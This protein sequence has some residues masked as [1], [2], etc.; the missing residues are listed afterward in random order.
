ML[1][2]NL[3]GKVGLITGGSK[4][5]GKACAK[6]LAEAGATVIINF[7][8]NKE[9]AQKTAEEIGERALLHQC[10]VSNP[11]EVRAM[12]NAI[13]EK[14]GRLDILVN[15]AGI[16][17]E[18]LLE[19]LPEESI[20]RIFDVNFFGAM[21]TSK[22][23]LPLMKDRGGSMIFMSSTSMYTGAGGG[24]HYAASKSALLGLLRNIAK[25]YGKYNI[26]SNGLAVTMVNTDLLKNRKTDDLK[27]KIEGVPLKRLCEPEE[28]G[29]T[30]AFLSSDTASYINGEMITMDGGRTYA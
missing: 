30:V 8:Q 15:N 4:G 14:F 1:E 5:I 6:A 11:E 2:I 17:S 25:D 7:S 20:R 16:T 28:I 12:M 29:G 27:S 21:Y 10:D 13:G 18:D 9:E 23:A 19:D 3:E 22:Y 24:A 26:R